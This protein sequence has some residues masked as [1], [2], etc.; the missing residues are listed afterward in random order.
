M[1]VVEIH[2]VKS[3]TLIKYMIDYYISIKYLGNNYEQDHDDEKSISIM[4]HI[5]ANIYL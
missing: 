4:W 1:M 2:E 5:P 3:Q